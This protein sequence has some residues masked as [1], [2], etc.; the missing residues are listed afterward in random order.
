MRTAWSRSGAYMWP[1]SSIAAISACRALQQ[2]GAERLPPR[3]RRPP[4]R[5]PSRRKP[6][7]G[8]ACR[9]RRARAA[10]A[11]PPA[12]RRA[13]CTTPRADVFD[14]GPGARPATR[15]SSS[16]SCSV[17]SSSRTRAE[18]AGQPPDLPLR[19]A[20]LAALQAGGQHRHRLAQPP[21]RHP[22]L[23][24]AACRR[25]RSRAG[26]WRFEGPREPLK[27][28]ASLHGEHECSW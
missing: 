8:R 25:P 28:H 10:R 12:A 20:G 19:L 13:R 22:G 21:R 6:A 2:P 9:R 24:H 11:S 17:T 3:L 16:R 7:G 27:Q 18:R 5:A 23:V 4:R 15:A 14:G 26:R 1:A